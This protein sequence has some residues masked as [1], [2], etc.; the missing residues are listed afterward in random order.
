[1]TEDLN[2]TGD[3]YNIVLMS[4]FI[5]YILF[6]VPS[7]LVSCISTTAADIDGSTSADHHG[8]DRSSNGSGHIF[9]WRLSWASGE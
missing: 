5:T 1:M 4:F 3:D 8:H 7:N 6:E 2:M 9:T